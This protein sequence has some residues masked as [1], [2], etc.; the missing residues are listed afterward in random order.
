MTAVIGTLDAGAGNDL[1]NVNVERGN[2]VPLDSTT[3]SSRSASPEL[4]ALQINGASD[5][6]D[7]QVQAGLLDIAAG[8]SIRSAVGDGELGRDVNV[9][10]A[11]DSLP[12][13]TTLTVGGTVMARARSTCSMATISS[14]CSMART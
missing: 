1:L 6:V 7:V 9:D 3:A 8:G 5:F 13:P 2:L 11:F 4:G 14:R 10:G 12:A